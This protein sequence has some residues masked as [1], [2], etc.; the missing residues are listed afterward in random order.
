MNT[1]NTLSKIFDRPLTY[2]IDHRSI[3]LTSENGKGV[4]ALAQP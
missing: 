4:S 3:T 2:R 1:E